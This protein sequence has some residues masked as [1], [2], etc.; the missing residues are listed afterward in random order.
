MFIVGILSWWYGMGWRLRVVAEK[1]RMAGL[2]DYFSF[3]LL[4]KTF[5]SPF[6]QISAGRVSG[7]FAMQWRA[8]IDRLISRCIGAVVRLIVLVVGVVAVICVG[9]FSTLGI[10]VWPFLPLLP[11]FGAILTFIGWTPS[12]I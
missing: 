12:W 8:F 5:F 3:D 2:L 11:F 9:L 4:L 6:R 7:S 1:E 10:A